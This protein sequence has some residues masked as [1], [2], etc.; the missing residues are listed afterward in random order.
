MIKG[1]NFK[2]DKINNGTTDY[3]TGTYNHLNYNEF[4]NQ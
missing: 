3:K 4:Q 1:R 2:Q